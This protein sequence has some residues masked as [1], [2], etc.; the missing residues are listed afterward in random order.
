MDY[1][2]TSEI[3][4][5]QLDLAEA[6]LAVLKQEGVLRNLVTTGEPTTEAVEQLA[7]L[8]DIVMKLSLPVATGESFAA[9]R[10]RDRLVK[11]AS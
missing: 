1:D 9:E 6:E 5:R 7:R 3:A 2:Q 11:A 10:T 4:L 8:R